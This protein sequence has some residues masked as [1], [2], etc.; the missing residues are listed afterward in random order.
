MVMKTKDLAMILLLVV[1]GGGFYLTLSNLSSL[2]DEVRNLEIALHLSREKGTPINSIIS[3]GQKNAVV[4]APS[5]S[6]QVV[7][8]QQEQVIIPTAIIFNTK[9][10]PLLQP[11]ANIPMIIESVAKAGDGQVVINIKAF[12]SEAE[13][14]SA[15]E[16]RDL[17]EMIDLV[18]VNQ[19]ALQVNGGF[20]SMPP[21]SVVTG[22]VLF[23]IKPEQKVMILQISTGDGGFRHYEFNFEKK[24][25]KETEIG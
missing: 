9:S 18:E 12:T 25:Y 3:E 6:T 23:K 10:S 8:N 4:I 2:R 24:S 20:Q 17:F 15:I 21:K 11:Q 5:T 14:Y 13:S 19:K 16:P 22:S 7:S 1:L